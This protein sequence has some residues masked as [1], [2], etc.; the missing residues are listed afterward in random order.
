MHKT[1]RQEQLTTAAPEA[2]FAEPSLLDLMLEQDAPVRKAA[3]PSM[4]DALVADAAPTGK[5]SRGRKLIVRNV[6]VVRQDSDVCCQGGL[7]GMVEEATEA[8]RPVHGSQISLPMGAVETD[9]DNGCCVCGDPGCGIGPFV[10][11][12]GGR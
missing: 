8:S 5:F 2:L 11:R 7:F 6:E 10:V 3:A 1:Q 12:K 9:R 4:L